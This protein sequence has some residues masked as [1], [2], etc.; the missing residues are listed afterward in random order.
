MGI[1]PETK[2]TIPK[3][4]SI[5]NYFRTSK[6]ASRTFY[7][8][9]SLTMFMLRSVFC[10]SAMIIP[11]VHANLVIENSVIPEV[12]GKYVAF[13]PQNNELNTYNRRPMKCEEKELAYKH[14]NNNEN[15]GVYLWRPKNQGWQ[16]TTYDVHRGTKIMML[17][18]KFSSHPS[19]GRD[20]WIILPRRMGEIPEGIPFT[21][22]I[23]R[24]L[25]LHIS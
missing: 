22:G 14:E 9:N 19:T 3:I 11:I 7:Q 5:K 12:N 24:D 15:G 4:I 21:R 17:S 8:Y 6:Q 25:T 23:R 13:R 2:P 10:V 1:K 18:Q 20:G 16:I